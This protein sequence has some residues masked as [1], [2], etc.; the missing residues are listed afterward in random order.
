[1][2][3]IREL[4]LQKNELQNAR[5]QNL[6]S[7]PSSPALGQIYYNTGDNNLYVW[8]GTWTDLT[9]QGTTAPDATTSVKGLI[10]LGGDLAGSGTSASSPVITAGAIDLGKIA[11]SLKPSGSAVDATEA[12]RALG[13]SA[14]QALPGNHVSVTNARTPTAHA[15]NHQPGATDSL[16]WPVINATGTLASRP[17]A[18]SGFNTGTFYY[19]TDDSGG[20]LYR[21]DGSTWTAMAPSKTHTHAQSDITGL[22][23]SLSAKADVASPT[24]TGTATIPTAAVTTFS[25]TPNFSGAATGQTAAVDTNT[26]QLA[27]TAYVVGQGYLKSATAASTYAPL[28]SPTFSG[29][30]SL[31]TGTTG[32]TQSA[33]DNTTKLATTAFVIGRTPID[34]A[35]GTGSLRTLGTGSTQAAAGDHTHAQ[36]H[37]QNTDLGTSSAYFY[38]VGTSA[39]DVRLKKSAAGEFSTRLGDDSGFATLQTGALTV[40]GNLT[41]TGTTTTINSNT[42]SVGD[43]LIVLNNDVLT[44]GATTENGGIEIQRFT[45]ATVAQNAGIIWD[46]SLK[47][48][49]TSFPASSGTGVI[50]KPLSRVHTETVLTVTGG[51]PYTI[52][53]NL[54]TREV[55]VTLRDTATNE[56]LP[57]D[58]TAATVDTVTILFG[59]SYASGAFVATVTG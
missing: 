55:Q 12:L 15:T 1:M 30:P 29:T 56:I 18:S 43:N 7:A 27:T 2:R 5:I 31:P 40:N 4:N 48:W 16:N 19:A 25:G 13:T 45:G 14:G 44:T 53:H 58:P 33:G 10:Q 37:T 57:A 28:A 26:T 22:A 42:L 35:T 24:F 39:A 54:N 9:A 3:L 8:D 17:L 41:V 23:T 36:L 47:R 6:A 38:L 59:A 50:T 21:S 32:V 49:T 20:T 11:G 34:G 46:E 51:T 52:T